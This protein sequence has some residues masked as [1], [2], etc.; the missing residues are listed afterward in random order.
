MAFR[1]KVRIYF[2]QGDPAHI[3]FHG[4]HTIIAQRVMEEYVENIGIPWKEWYASK[5]IFLP[6]VEF[7]IQFKKPLHPGEEYFVDVQFEK[8]GHKSLTTKYKILSLKEEVCCLIKAVYVC[9]DARLF[10]SQ[11]FPKHWLPLL[12]KE[13]GSS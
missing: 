5:D 11:A 2:D 1:K 10:K 4:Q 12:Q 7:L 6:V 3:A 9:V 13:A 8:V